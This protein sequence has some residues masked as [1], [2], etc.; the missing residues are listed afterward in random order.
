[1]IAKQK[2]NQSGFAHIFIL[3]L[4]VMVVIGAAGF[5]VFSKDGSKEKGA[6]ANEWKKDCTGTDRVAMTHKPMDMA[7]VSTVSPL[8]LTAGAHVTPIDHLY[9]YPKEGP[10]DKYPVYAMADGAI[11]EIEVREVN[12]SSGESRPP[13]Y[14]IIMQHS[15]QT[16]SYFDLVTKLD[17]S[18]LAKA[19]QAATKGFRGR[20]EI[21]AGQEVGRIGAQSLDTAIYNLDM[22]LKGFIHPSMYGAEPWKVHTDDFFSY[23]SEPNK[24]EMLA[25]NPRTV[26][27]RSGKIDYDQAG[28]LI[29]NWFKQGTNGYAGPKNSHIGDG[30]GRGYWSGHLAIFYD[31]LDPSKIDVSIGDFKNGQPMA[32]QVTDNKPDPADVSSSSGV[33]KYELLTAQQGV[34]QA[35]GSSSSSRVEGVILVQVMPNEKLKVEIFPG[36]TAAQVTGFTSAA[37][38]YER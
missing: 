16:I 20:I 21:K 22:T 24:G 26:E 38:N 28:K 12:V 5:L 34:N 11:I 30:S 33:V 17:P 35:S 29:G 19:P 8:G 37:M 3:I 14:R 6:S 4:I 13:E 10:R 7:D 31:A 27:P 36:K 23:F 25:K 15:C 1:M 2:S 18:I 32:F 9:F